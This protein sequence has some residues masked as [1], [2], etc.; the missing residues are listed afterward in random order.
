MNY[1]SD[2]GTEGVVLKREHGLGGDNGLCELLV[3]APEV[4]C[5]VAVRIKTGF[6]IKFEDSIIPS[7]NVL[8]RVPCT[9]TGLCD[10]RGKPVYNQ[11]GRIFCLLR[12]LDCV[13]IDK[14]VAVSWDGKRFK[15]DH[16]WQLRGG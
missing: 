11:D 10:S 1:H 6:S 7:G 8:A 15:A 13:Y 2:A 9:T 3:K 12:V 14:P 5:A 16:L 4:C